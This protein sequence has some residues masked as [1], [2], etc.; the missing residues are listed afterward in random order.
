MGWLIGRWEWGSDERVA[1]L[2]LFFF[3][4]EKN[5]SRMWEGERGSHLATP[6]FLE[7]RGK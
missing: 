7:Q 3:C 1:H 5:K 2:A 6:L 4:H